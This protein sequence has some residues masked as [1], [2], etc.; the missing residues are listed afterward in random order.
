MAMAKKNESSAV[1]EGDGFPSIAEFYKSAGGT[2]CGACSQP[3]EIRALI[4]K[5]LN[6]GFG[7]VRVTNY[8]K[9]VRGIEISE[10]K[11]AHHKSEGH[12][13]PKDAD[14]GTDDAA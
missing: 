14:A 12:H 10:A 11:I 9:K 3:E 5:G 8:L 6:E 7:S 2:R 1:I 13:L 4:D